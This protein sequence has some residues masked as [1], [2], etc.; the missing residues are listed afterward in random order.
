MSGWGLGCVKTRRRAIAIEQTFRQSRAFN[1]PKLKACSVPIC[2]RKIFSSRFNFLRFYTPRSFAT[3]SNQQQVSH[4]RSCSVR[5][6]KT[7]RC[8]SDEK[9]QQTHEQQ[10][11]PRQHEPERPARGI[12]LRARQKKC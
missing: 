9:G 2:P 10:R 4:V 12:A 6:Q 1:A 5:Y 8:R 11:S 3:G 7:V